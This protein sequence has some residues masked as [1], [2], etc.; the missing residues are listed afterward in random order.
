MIRNEEGVWTV[1]AGICFDPLKKVTFFR[2]SVVLKVTFTKDTRTMA[3]FKVYLEYEGTRYSGWQ[4]QKNARTI[5][6]EI[7]N[8]AAKVFGTRDVDLQGSGRTDTGVHAQEQVAHFKT[9]SNIALFKLQQALDSLLP[10]DIRVTSASQTRVDF[11]SRYDA[12]EKTYRY[13]ILNQPQGDVFLRRYVYH[14]A[15]ADLKIENMRRAAAMLVG[16]HDFS[17]F[18]INRDSQGSNNVRR[19]KNITVIRKGKLIIIEI[20]GSGFLHKMVRGIVGTLIEIGRGKLSIAAMKKILGAKSRK[21]AGPTAPAC[22][23]CLMKV[24]Y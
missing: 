8:A 23:L 11:H 19:I 2:D 5:Q 14:F 24:R 4:V 18:K 10:K 7:L 1:C 13:S 3:R 15:P 17:S 20:T 12:K 16:R 6:G 22:G 9:A 21:A